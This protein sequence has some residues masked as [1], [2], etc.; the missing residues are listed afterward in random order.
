MIDSHC[1]LGIDD[2]N[3][4]IEGYLARAKEAGVSD[5]LTVACSY[6]QI[7]QLI[8]MGTYPNVHTAFGIHPEGAVHFEYQKSLDLYQKHPEIKAVG[9]IGLDY[10]YNP[11]TKNEQIQAFFDQ[12]RLANQIQ[13]PIIIHAR[14]ADADIIDILKESHKNNLLK[15]SGVMHCFCGS[16]ALAEVALEVGLYISVSGI[17]TFKNAVELRNTIAKIPLNRLMIET[18]AP[19]LAPHP[20][21][22]KKNE[23]SFVKYTLES[24]AKL[25]QENIETVEKQTSKN[26][27][28]VFVGE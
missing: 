20:F 16:E 18:D 6:D 7:D 19:Y 24:L 26:F 1:H 14:D 21:R 10:Y 17:I 11:E 5:I 23:P 8:H 22:G 27:F 28:K 13:K 4:N 12:I 3:E 2:F 25:K 15:K 9:E